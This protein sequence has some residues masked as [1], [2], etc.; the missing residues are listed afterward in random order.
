MHDILK[1]ICYQINNED[2]HF[3]ILNSVIEAINHLEESGYIEGNWH[4]LGFIHI[5]LGT[6]EDHAIRLH[7][8][9]HRERRSQK[10]FYPIHTHKFELKSHILSGSLRNYI[11]DSSF[12]SSEQNIIY[13]VEYNSRESI[14]KQTGQKVIVEK[15]IEGIYKKGDYYSVKR[16]D[17]HS[18]EVDEGDFTAT[19]ALTYNIQDDSPLVIGEVEG[20]EKYIYSRNKCT[21]EEL[22]EI[23]SYLKQSIQ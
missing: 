23:I 12:V 6:F 21:H 10:P 11:Y 1:K 18:S 14:I 5:P 4:P 19:I 15:R 16:G 13:N 22:K 2:N 3:N 8:W 9:S 17:F 20:N 7:I